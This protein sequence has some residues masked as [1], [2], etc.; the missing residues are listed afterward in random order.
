MKVRAGD[1]LLSEPFMKD[2]NFKR[3]VILLCEHNQQGSFG[4]VINKK[5][6][7]CIQDVLPDFPI[8]DI[9]LYAGGP[10]GL[11]SLHYIHT[12]GDL[13]EGS[14]HVKDNVYWS[15]NFEQI[16]MLFE[17]ESIDASKFRFFIGYSGWGPN[18]IND[19]MEAESWIIS[20]NYKDVLAKD[21][22]M[23]KSILE[24][25]GGEFKFYSTFPEDPALN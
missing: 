12:Y 10:V 9:E 16:K 23:W 15:G 13:I 7:L 22:R 21:N 3:A 5:M 6:D 25:M 1:I 14:I 18:Q 11:D 24:C 20:R 17:T 19:E 8:D 4:L 2:E